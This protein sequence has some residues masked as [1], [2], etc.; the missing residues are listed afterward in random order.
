MSA[1]IRETLE[2]ADKTQGWKMGEA[3]VAYVT[4]RPVPREE[5]EMK[6]IVVTLP[7]EVHNW[8]RSSGQIAGTSMAAY[9]RDLLEQRL[10]EERPKP[11]FGAF[12]SGFT[13]TGRLAGEI[14]L[15]PR[16]WR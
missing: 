10:H 4:S 6:R 1:V 15:E 9:I 11:R 2:R 5:A 16:S 8:V 7:D 13:D 14:M 3:R 12:D